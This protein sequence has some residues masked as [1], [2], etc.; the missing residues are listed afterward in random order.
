MNICIK[1]NEYTIIDNIWENVYSKI[2]KVL[3]KKNNIYYTIKIISITHLREEEIEY[4]QNEINIL[5]NINNEHIIKYIDSFTD[6]NNI[7]IL[8][9]YN[10]GSYLN[11]FIKNYKDKNILIDENILYN[12]ILDLC[13]GIKEIH[14]NNLIHRDLKPKNI[15]ITKNNKVKIINFGISK[16][17][18]NKYKYN[19]IG[20]NNYMAPEMLKGEKYSNK[21][22]IWAL[23][24]IIYE[25][26]TLN[27]CFQDE[28]IFGIINK[29]INEKHGKININKYND[30]W[31]NFIDL[32]LKKEDKERPD[33]NEIYEYLRKQIKNNSNNNLN[34][35]NENNLE[36]KKNIKDK[37]S[38]NYKEVESIKIRK[39]L[40]Y[41]EIKK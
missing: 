20:T 17:L 9:E 2:Y 24:C 37:V 23:G 6:N 36:M 35:I 8:M 21:V 3:N 33:I 10:D 31:Q 26:F 14:E 12:I 5:S 39:E 40:S 28:N 13:L 38:N 7:Y 25:L 18:D 29:I 4:I 1:S 19:L 11:E 15:F 16:K 22:D 30:K 34:V 41:E 32:L 27:I